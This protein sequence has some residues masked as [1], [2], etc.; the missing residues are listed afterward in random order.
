MFKSPPLGWPASIENQVVDYLADLSLIDI[1]RP[2]GGR[3][4]TL[5]SAHWNRL[6]QQ[7]VLRTSSERYPVA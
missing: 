1:D 7:A 3:Q 2:V 5:A 6:E 4:E